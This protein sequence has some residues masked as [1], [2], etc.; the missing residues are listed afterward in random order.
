M[1]QQSHSW[2]SI[3]RKPDIKKIHAPQCL[4]QHYL[5]QPSHGSNLNV[6]RQMKE[7][8]IHIYNGLLLSN[9]EERNNAICNNVDGTRDH[10]K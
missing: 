5:Q 4:L 9:K 1:T 7:D 2:P 3:R 10:T 6:H 8:V